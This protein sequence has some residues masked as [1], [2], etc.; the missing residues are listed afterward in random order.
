MLYWGCTLTFLLMLSPHGQ[1]KVPL[2]LSALDRFVMESFVWSYSAFY[3][4][5][6]FSFNQSCLTI[7]TLTINVVTMQAPRAA[8][9]DMECRDKFLIQSTIVSSGT[10]DE[11]ITASMV[12]LGNCCWP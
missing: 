1:S 7:L 3:F 9:P 12:S 11:D 2:Q 4:L 10:T 6:V 8:P 5:I